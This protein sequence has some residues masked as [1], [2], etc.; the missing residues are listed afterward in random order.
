[1]ADQ[2]KIQITNQYLTI[3]N[4]QTLFKTSSL[5]GV[6]AQKKMAPQPRP[7]QPNRWDLPPN[8]CRQAGVL[9]V[10]YQP[11]FTEELHLVL[12]RR[13][14]YP[15]VHSGQISFPGGRHEPGETLTETALRE[16]EEEVGISP[17]TLQM[18]GRLSSL[19]IP[20]SN[21]CLYPYVAYSPVYPT[22]QPDNKEVAEVIETPLTLLLD[23]AN[24][25]VEMWDLGEHGKRRVPFFNVFG[26]H[27]WGATAM[28]L[29]E[30]LTL[31]DNILYKTGD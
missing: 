12:I 19:Y 7:G 30:C 28:I 2:H 29:S 20:P 11:T 8:D 3:K 18:I 27:V 5:P 31:L 17:K 13:P 15:G 23:P 6:K 9:L 22:F 4:I 1:M 24:R 10:L 26:H 16:T 25:H 14:E 21:F